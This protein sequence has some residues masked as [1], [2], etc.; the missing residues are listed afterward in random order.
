MSSL[1]FNCGK[2]RRR[3][4]NL[5]HALPQLESNN[6]ILVMTSK[7]GAR[8][9]Q[10]AQIEGARDLPFDP[11]EGLVFPTKRSGPVKPVWT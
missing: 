2:A 4:A 8:K 9:A 1:R 5:C 7:K 6:D 3:V 10:N 11:E